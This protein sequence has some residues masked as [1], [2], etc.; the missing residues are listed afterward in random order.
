MDSG[1]SPEVTSGGNAPFTVKPG[2]I[3]DGHSY[4]YSIMASDKL[5]GVPWSGATPMC[6]FK[7]DTTPP[8]L[9][10]PATVNDPATQFPPSGNGQTPKIYAGQSGAVPFS[11]VDP[12]PSGMNTSG[13][14]CL[15]WS[16]DPQLAGAAWQCGA[17]MPT[18]QIP[19]VTPGH[20]GT[21]ILYVQAE[22]NAGNLSAIAPYA[23]YVPWNPNGPA[24]V[25]G[26]VTGDGVPDVLA[27][28]AAATC[29]PTPS[30]ATPRPGVPPRC[31]RRRRPAPRAATPGPTTAPPTAVACAAA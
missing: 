18:G 30:P 25:F 9:S 1:Y 6:F 3:K 7:V 14:A 20:W 31:W 29:V 8:T 26:D 15:R 27:P 11:A 12:N 24:P 16:W 10:F 23:F 28:D 5:P 4:G 21:N 19:N 13:Q 17:A 22:D 2:V